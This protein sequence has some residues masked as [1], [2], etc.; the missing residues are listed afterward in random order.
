[1]KNSK[2]IA[3]IVGSGL[4]LSAVAL[5]LDG[6]APVKA[7]AGGAKPDAQLIAARVERGKYIVNTTG[8]GDCHTP[9]K[10]GPNGPEPDLTRMLSGHPESMQL[11]HAPPA[12]GP[13]IASAAATM[14]AWAGPWGT[15]FT[16][17]LTP[18]RETGTGAWTEDNFVQTIRKGRHLGSGRQLL[19]PMPIP[20]YRNFNDEDL[21]S[22]YWY[23]QSVPAVKNRVPQPLPPVAAK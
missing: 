17:N 14:T 23:L 16:A 3:L 18:D 10:L 4:M 9:V 1:M 7:S 22:I 13:W 2:M 8:C 20:F 15:S 6:A 11:P 21:K 12:S 5:R 19:P